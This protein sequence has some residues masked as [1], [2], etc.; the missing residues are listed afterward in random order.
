MAGVFISIE[1]APIESSDVCACPWRAGLVVR[2]AGSGK[3]RDVVNTCSDTIRVWDVFQ[4]KKELTVVAINLKIKSVA[5]AILN[6]RDTA[7]R[8]L[9]RAVFG[10]RD[11]AI[12]A[13]A[14]LPSGKETIWIH[15]TRNISMSAEYIE[16]PAERIECPTESRTRTGPEFMSLEGLERF[17]TS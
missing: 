8:K 17:L 12:T 13:A 9:A 1:R 6:I 3:I 2:A 16:W 5:G 4:A 14:R 7:I 10:Q 11:D 15:G